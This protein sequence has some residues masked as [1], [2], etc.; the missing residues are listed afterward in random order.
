MARVTRNNA[1]QQAMHRTSHTH[2]QQ[3]KTSPARPRDVPHSTNHC[4]L[5]N[6]HCTHTAARTPH[7]AR[8]T[9]PNTPHAAHRKSHPVTHAASA[10][11]SHKSCQT[12]ERRW[13]A[14]GELV[15]VQD[16]LP[17]GHTNSHRV[18]PLHPTPPPTPASSPQRIS[19]HRI[20]SINIKSNESQ[21]AHCMLSLPHNTVCE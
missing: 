5:R 9:A 19:V 8:Y 21:S 2:T 3:A 4:A 18:T 13:N 20:A 7:T 14:A 12:A 10:Q 11:H 15:A 1:H 16:Q 6:H 17:A